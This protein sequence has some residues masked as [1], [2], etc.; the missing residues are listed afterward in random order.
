MIQRI[1]VG[2]IGIQTEVVTIADEVTIPKEI[3]AHR[4]VVVVDGDEE[5][6]VDEIEGGKQGTS[7]GDLLNVDLLI[8]AIEAGPFPECVFLA[9]G[10]GADGFGIT[11]AVFD[12]IAI[13]IGGL[14]LLGIAITKVEG[15]GGNGFA[16]IDVARGDVIVDSLVIG[17]E[18]DAIII[19]RVTGVQS[20]TT[21]KGQHR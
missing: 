9:T 10:G 2:Q 1:V 16:R 19:V 17:I 15:A 18:F 5:Q 8:G 6:P 3:A 4:F 7:G 21:G 12:D 11:M 20:G 13:E 14:V